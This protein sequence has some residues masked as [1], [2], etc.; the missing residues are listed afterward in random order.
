MKTTKKDFEL[1]IKHALYWQ[2]KLSLLDWHIYF[3]HKR[4]VDGSFANTSCSLTGRGV[5]INFNTIWKERKTTSAELKQCA[6]H[7]ILH[8]VTA[9]LYIEAR[10]RY[11][12]EYAV[13]S[14]EHAIV[15]R[16]TNVIFE[17]L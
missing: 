8:I 6:L 13:E 14:A 3:N 12:D 11:T 2:K 4:I 17:N 15:T 16:L 7:E 9:P 1:F 5:T 10:A